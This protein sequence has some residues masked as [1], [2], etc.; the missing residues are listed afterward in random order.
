MGLLDGATPQ[1]NPSG[2]LLGQSQLPDAG[3]P[4][5]TTVPIAPDE[6]AAS[7]DRLMQFAAMYPDQITGDFME[8]YYRAQENKRANATMRIAQTRENV[9][10]QEEQ[11]EMVIQEGMR[12]NAVKGGYEGVID[13]LEGV[14]PERAL[15][16]NKAKTKLDQDLLKTDVMKAQ[17]PAQIAG[18]MLEGYAVLGKVGSAILQ[19]DPSE[20]DNMYQM[21][22]PVIK[23]VNP[24]ASE[25]LNGDATNMFALAI[26]QA[27]PENQLFK[28]Q[29]AA[30][31]SESALGKIDTDLKS[32]YAA[33]YDANDPT[34]QAL[35]AQREAYGMA[36]IKSR[37]QLVKTQLSIDA[38][39]QNIEQ[40]NMQ[41]QEMFNKNLEKASQPF[42]DFSEN[43]VGFKA[44]ID[45]LKQDPNNY[46]AQV[47][48]QTLSVKMYQKGVLTD[49][50]MDRQLS[51][52][53]YPSALKT[54]QAVAQG[55][56]VNLNTT[57]IQEM[58]GAF[59]Q[60]EKIQLE[61]QQGRE[62]QFATAAESYGN[63]V[64]WKTARKPSELYLQGKQKVNSPQKDAPEQALQMLQ[65]NPSLAP[66]FK[67]K[68]GYLPGEAK[69]TG[70][71]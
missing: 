39:Q 66:Q 50:D 31:T 36:A 53:G 34:I 43:A 56:K 17:H 7:R 33:G 41:S 57:E 9:K 61:R 27:T 52:Y 23:T 10:E 19:A 60:I 5:P 63:L 48:L 54:M 29:K 1:Q 37:A 65:A 68:Y 21:M 3:P 70:T 6:G 25:S 40:G 62:S 24:N 38:K 20:R 16:F 26:A 59:E 22:L 45:T 15:V 4:G 42:N 67:A 8:G 12:M 14:D 51:A 71:K 28:S 46:Q 44:A 47:N 13:Y 49:P 69:S 30:V 11:R 32:R 2:G 64:D 58:S 55:K 35:Q 18:A